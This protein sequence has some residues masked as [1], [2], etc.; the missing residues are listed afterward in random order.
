MKKLLSLIALLSIALYCTQPVFAQSTT[1]EAEVGA[2][3]AASSFPWGAM[4]FFV[5]VAVVWMLYK[6]KFPNKITVN[7]CAPVI[8]EEQIK[9]EKEKLVAL[10]ED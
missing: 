3:A 1:P 10:E 5:A 6:Q 7:T 2:T 9:R 8:D 4:I